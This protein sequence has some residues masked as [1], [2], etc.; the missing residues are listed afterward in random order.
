MFG[1]LQGTGP[2]VGGGLLALGT[3]VAGLLYIT[4]NLLMGKG[5][6]VSRL[7]IAFFYAVLLFFVANGI[8]QI[9]TVR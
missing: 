5:K 8:M 6:D 9:L 1:P 4:V 2:S 3:G 7:K